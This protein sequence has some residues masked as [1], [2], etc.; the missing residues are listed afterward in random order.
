M[1]CSC[2]E[3]YNNMRLDELF[4]NSDL[5]IE[6]VNNYS[7]YIDYYVPGD[8]KEID[9]SKTSFSFAMDDNRIA[10]NINVPNIIN[11]Y[12]QNNEVLD[13]EGYFDDEKIIYN[14]DGTYND[15]N[16]EPVDYFV[17]IYQIS[18][19][20]NLIYFVSNNLAF[21]GNCDFDNTYLVA[22]KI[23]QMA[24][25]AKL[26]VEEIVSDFSLKDAIDYN[27]ET[28]DPFPTIM[29]T[30]GNIEDILIGNDDEMPE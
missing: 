4:L 18:D 28:F 12:Y 19:S 7:K 5:E 30:D 13:N 14:F 22:K 21:Y 25:S 27:K 1:L 17:N 9:Y 3:K 2:S 15:D 29:P 8:V 16:N 11:K 24:K 20:R 10:M 6:N 23:F 26:N